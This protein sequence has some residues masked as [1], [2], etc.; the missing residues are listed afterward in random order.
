MRNL[1]VDELRLDGR[2]IAAG[3][4]ALH[5]AISSSMQ[6]IDVKGKNLS[7]AWLHGTSPSLE[8]DHPYK[9]S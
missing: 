2:C 9:F 6:V 7:A 4:P 1:R 8:F 3:V 5:S